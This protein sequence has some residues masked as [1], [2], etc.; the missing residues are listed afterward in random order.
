MRKNMTDAVKAISSRFSVF[1]SVFSLS[2]FML[3]QGIAIAVQGSLMITERPLML[4]EGLVMIASAFGAR[5]AF[6]KLH[7]RLQSRKNELVA[8]R[9][10]PVFRYGALPLIL[11]GFNSMLATWLF[12]GYV[13]GP[14]D[15]NWP[16]GTMLFLCGGAT[17]IQWLILCPYDRRRLYRWLEQNPSSESS[18]DR[19]DPFNPTTPSGRDAAHFHAIGAANRALIEQAEA[20]APQRRSYDSGNGIVWSP[21]EIWEQ[22]HSRRSIAT[23]NEV[24]LMT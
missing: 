5:D 18:H 13:G 14:A 8:I 19:D 24:R 7:T 17:F 2:S 4:L 21:T 11:G 9:I 12:H 22:H 15:Q 6:L 10:N 20:N 1:L 23:P 3:I 16:I